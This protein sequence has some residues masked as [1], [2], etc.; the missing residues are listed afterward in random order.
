M[1]ILLG[2]AGAIEIPSR[3]FNGWL[4]DRKIMKGFTQLAINMLVTGI[5]SIICAA[6]SGT[7]GVYLGVF[8]CLILLGLGLLTC[9]PY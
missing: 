1:A 4:A 9:A 2:I 7:A 8:R 5:C 6:V 3:I